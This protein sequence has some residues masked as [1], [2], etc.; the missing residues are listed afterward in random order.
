LLSLR[1]DWSGIDANDVEITAGHLTPIK[2]KSVDAIN[3]RIALNYKAMDDMSFRAS[4]G[5]SFRAPTLYERFIRDVGFLTGTPNPALDKESMT[6]YEIGMFKQFGDKVSFDIAGFIN[7]YE[8]LIE[9]EKLA[10]TTFQ[11]QNITKAR[12]WGIETGLNYRPSSKWALNAVYTYVN[13]KNS[14]YKPSTPAIAIDSSPV[15]EWLPMRPEHTASASVTFKPVS[16]LGLNFNGRYVGKYKA[17]NL[18]TNTAGLNYPGDFIVLNAGL[19]YQACETT[20]LSLLCRNI[21]NMQ[22]EEAEWFRAPECSY[23]AGMDFTF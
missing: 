2:N 9:S 1:Y 10:G 22:Y 5:T 19:K 4:W 18:Y 12:I 13:A 20:S 7:D 16:Q 23:V 14:D 21:G 15:P 8:N 17:V 3:P 6:A 11:F